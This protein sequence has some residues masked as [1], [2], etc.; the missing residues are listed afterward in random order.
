MSILRVWII[1]IIPKTRLAE[2]DGIVTVS[3][4]L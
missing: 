1:T 3:D 2:T 4:K